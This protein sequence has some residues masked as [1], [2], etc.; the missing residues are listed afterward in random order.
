M[1][2]CNNRNPSNKLVTSG[3]KQTRLNLNNYIARYSYTFLVPFQQSLF[4]CSRTSMD[5]FF[6]NQFMPHHELNRKK[7]QALPSFAPSDISVKKNLE[8]AEYH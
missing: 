8:A 1:E 7:N 6:E 5:R 4:V 3:I 2:T